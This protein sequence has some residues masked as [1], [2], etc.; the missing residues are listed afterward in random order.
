MNKYVCVNEMKKKIST[1]IMV[2]QVNKNSAQF[3]P[4][5]KNDEFLN[6]QLSQQRKYFDSTKNAP[7]QIFFVTGLP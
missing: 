1:Q 5:L 7:H 2:S 6:T 4:R 3:I